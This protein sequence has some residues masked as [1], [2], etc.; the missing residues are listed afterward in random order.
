MIAPPKRRLLGV[1]AAIALALS[2]ATPALA[3]SFTDV[4]LGPWWE[5]VTVRSG[6]KNYGSGSALISVSSSSQNGANFWVT[7]NGTKCSYSVDVHV[8]QNKGSSYYNSST[9]GTVV[10]HAHQYGYGP[11]TDT[12]SGDVYFNN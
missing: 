7:K 6:T 1:L 4:T 2:F 3:L 12:I 5:D 8:G 9:S 10:L 11:S